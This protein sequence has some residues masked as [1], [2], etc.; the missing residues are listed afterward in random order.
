MLQN[1]VMHTYTVTPLQIKLNGIKDKFHIFEFRVTVHSGGGLFSVARKEELPA[2]R[3]IA[4]ELTVPTD[5]PYRVPSVILRDYF[6]GQELT[7]RVTDLMG[8]FSSLTRE[9][10]PAYNCLRAEILEKQKVEEL[11]KFIK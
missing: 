6:T 7:D 1:G 3:V 10:Y 4:E 2:M 9:I 5:Y 8:S 11:K